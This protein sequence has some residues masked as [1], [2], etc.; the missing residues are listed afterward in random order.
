MKLTEHKIFSGMKTCAVAVAVCATM[1]VPAYAADNG[2]STDDNDRITAELALCTTHVYNIGLDQNPESDA[3]KQLMRDVVA[4]K[5][6]VMTQQM[7]K[8]YEYLDATLRRFRT[9]L[10]KAILTTK[11]QA[12]GATDDNGGS[13]GSYRSGDRNV[14]LS[15]AEN[16]LLKTSTTAGL[17]CL[18][19][20]IRIVLNAVAGGNIG[21]AK[22][23]LDKDLGFAVSYGAIGGSAGKYTTIAGGALTSCNN[24]ATNRD[25]VNACAYDLNIQVMRKIEDDQ[26]KQRTTQTKP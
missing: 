19:N 3:D 16:C 7:Y 18:Q 25:A 15:G 12:A 26:N 23:Q 24:V 9:Q 5:T 10:E 2:C 22:R 4:L 13:S 1:M 20:N 11:L 17:Q 8:Q 6:T 21:D 14:V